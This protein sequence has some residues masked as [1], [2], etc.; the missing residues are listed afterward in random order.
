M[1]RFVVFMAIPLG[2]WAALAVI[3]LACVRLYLSDMQQTAVHLMHALNAYVSEAEREGQPIESETL[4]RKLSEIAGLRVTLFSGEGDLLV[5][6]DPAGTNPP[7]FYPAA[8]MMNTESGVAS[9]SIT[10]YD[11]Q[12]YLNQFFSIVPQSE[13]RT[14]YI[15]CATIPLEGYAKL[16]LIRKWIV[17]TAGALLAAAA[18]FYLLWA[19]ASRRKTVA[20][21]DSSQNL[22]HKINQIELYAN[23]RISLL[24]TALSNIDSGIILFGTDCS[25]LMMNPKAKL[26]TGAKNSLFFPN[27]PHPESDYP[28][29]LTAIL[30][31]VRSS[32]ESKAALHRD[33]HTDEGKIL[34]VHTDIIY[35]KYVPYT[36]YGVHTYITDV[37][38]KRKME[39][40]RN[41]FVSNVSHELRTP[42]TLISGFAETLQNWRKLDKDDFKRAVSIIDIESKR[43]KHMISQLLDLSRIES[44]TGAPKH[45]SI[46]PVEAIKSVCSSIHALAEK[47]Q[48]HFEATLPD[49]KAEIFGDE[50]SV[51]QIVTNLCENA[52]KYT[53]AGGNVS[54]TV[55][56]DAQSLRIRVVDTGIGIP[57]SEIPHIFDRFYRVEKS[58]NSKYGGSG[59]GLSITKALIED[60]GGKISVESDLH[61]GSAFT[62]QLPLLNGAWLEK[63][64]T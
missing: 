22:L 48:V 6:S 9:F 24:S 21:S 19:R 18:L 20:V 54:L 46:D 57:E 28:P 31:M 14:S 27:Q 56:L 12:Y 29:V 49:Q 38:E 5:D 50:A 16:L 32:I 34:S 58:R 37:T 43:L 10:N 53:P 13:S 60:L 36:F 35:S 51:I 11:R 40:V 52:I 33:L 7:K 23:K 62:V 1:K 2:A 15:I 8:N 63:E 25:I 41:E 61:A 47:H 4:V 45:R 3:S 30:D 59:L 39:K 64:A 55:E 26:L 17:L 44:R 42:L